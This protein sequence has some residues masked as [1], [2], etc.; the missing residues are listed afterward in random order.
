MFAYSFV[1]IECRAQHHSSVLL[2]WQY[3]VLK[4]NTNEF[5]SK[6]PSVKVYRIGYTI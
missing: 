2:M 4:I 1:G 6:R 5:E 3:T